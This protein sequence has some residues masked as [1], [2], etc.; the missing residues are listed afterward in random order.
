MRCRVG[1]C[2]RQLDKNGYPV[3]YCDW[4]QGRC[5]TQKK[6]FNINNPFDRFAIFVLVPAI[7]LIIITV[8]YV[9]LF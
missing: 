5:P 9:E 1:G 4:Q 2:D 6:S 8:V 3:E 7:L